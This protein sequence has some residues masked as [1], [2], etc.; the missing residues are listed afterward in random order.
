[1]TNELLRVVSHVDLSL[2]LLAAGAVLARVAP[3]IWLAPFLG[4]R[5]VPTLVKTTLALALTVAIAPQ[6]LPQVER[7]HQAAPLVQAA[8][9]LKEAAVGAA[10]GFVVGLAFLA[11]EA[12][13]RLADTARGAN[14]AE[15]IEPQ[16]GGRTS[17]LGDLHF[18]LALV[19]FLALGGHRLFLLGLGASYEALP[20]ASFPAAAGLK[21]L[22]LLAA[23]LTADV[24]LLALTLA[25][26][27]VAALLLT[28][29]TLGIVN[30][31]VPSANV[32]FLAMPLK[33]LIGIGVLVL[34]VGLLAGVLPRVLEGAVVQVSRLL[35]VLRG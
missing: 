11:A 21:G 35:G 22:A 34:S 18:Q 24:L 14:L 1:M 9:L 28:D 33:A 13:G 17:P 23:R 7:L 27:V 26:P 20:L 31:F 4:G 19:L 25:A 15:V 2:T 30:R 3:V 32:F 12:A 10:L 16:L 8:V 6:L 29:V 5:L